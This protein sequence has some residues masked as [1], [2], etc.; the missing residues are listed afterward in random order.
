MALDRRRPAKG[1][2]TLGT[3][4]NCTVVCANHDTIDDP[5]LPCKNDITGGHSKQ[6]QIMSVKIGKY[7]GGCVYRRSYLLWSPVI[8]R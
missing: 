2:G 8:P 5:Q 7:I 3:P 1:P 6:D 4:T